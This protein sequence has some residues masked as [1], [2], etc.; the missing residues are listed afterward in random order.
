MVQNEERVMCGDKLFLTE[1]F[2]QSRF[3]DHRDGERFVFD[4]L[5]L[6]SLINTTQSIQITPEADMLLK[7]SSKEAYGINMKIQLLH[8]KEKS[9]SV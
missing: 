8:D 1:S 7:V 5:I 9:S 6:L 2:V 4:D 3:I